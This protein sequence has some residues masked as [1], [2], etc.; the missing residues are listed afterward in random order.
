[1]KTSMIN[2]ASVGMVSQNLCHLLDVYTYKIHLL[3]CFLDCNVKIK[4][5]KSV[6]LIGG[7][8]KCTV[9]LKV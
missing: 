6:K 9:R 2:T 4:F 5:T 7:F 3:H 1:M 8:F